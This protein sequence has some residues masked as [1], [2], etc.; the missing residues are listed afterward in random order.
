MK[1]GDEVGKMVRFQVCLD[2]S[3]RQRL[4]KHALKAGISMAD[5]IRRALELFLESKRKEGKS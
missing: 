4:R 2:D 5:A 1:G 3:L